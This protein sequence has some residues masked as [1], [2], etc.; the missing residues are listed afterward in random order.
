[1]SKAES[2]SADELIAIAKT[3]RTRGLRGELVADLL[4]D[5]PERF[6]GLDRVIAVGPKGERLP[7]ELEEHW[8]QE[9]RV[10]LRFAGYGS[11]DEAKKLVGYEIAVPEAERVELE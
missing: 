6:E 4:T 9:H 10:V 8:F 3:V 1:M 7:L 11:V 5:F 2:G